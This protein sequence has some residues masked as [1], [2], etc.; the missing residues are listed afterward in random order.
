MHDYQADCNNYSFSTH[1]L[2]DRPN[3]HYAKGYWPRHVSSVTELADVIASHCWIGCVF[4]DGYKVNDNFI[5]SDLAVFDFDKPLFTLNDALNFF[6]RYTHVI[7]TS[8]SHGIWKGNEAPCDRFRVVVPWE[9]RIV[10]QRDYDFSTKAVGSP[11]HAD[12]KAFKASQF[13]R[14]CKIVSVKEDGEK[15]RVYTAPPVR[16]YPKGRF[17][18]K[19]QIPPAISAVLRGALGLYGR[20]DQSYMCA[21]ELSKCG[22]S[23]DEV[24]Q[25]I[26]NSKLMDAGDEDHNKDIMR[27]AENGFKK[28]RTNISGPGKDDSGDH[29]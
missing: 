16:D 21:A 26:G 3:T 2:K 19:R 20:H 14:P 1:P 13:F 29:A 12:P 7:G 9:R 28:G 8:K 6:A 17:E 23:L 4:K 18:S 15:M 27:T 24:L 11:L 25:I 10:T 5:F 22:F